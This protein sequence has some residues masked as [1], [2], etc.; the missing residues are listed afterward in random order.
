MKKLISLM[1]IVI[2]VNFSNAYGQDTTYVNMATALNL[3]SNVS[4]LNLGIQY[5]GPFSG[6][7]GVEI[8][9]NAP[10]ITNLFN[11]L[12]IVKEFGNEPKVSLINQNRIISITFSSISVYGVWF[13]VNTKSG[14]TFKEILEEKYSEETKLILIGKSCI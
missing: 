5:P 6:L 1:M 4:T 14:K 7:C 13:S 8:R 10:D 2:M 9:S 11:D 12:N 3:R